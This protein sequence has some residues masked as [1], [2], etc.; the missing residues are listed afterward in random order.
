L[1]NILIDFGVP[2]KQVRL[3]EICLNETY[4][5][6]KACIHKHLSDNFPT[7]NGLKQGDALSS[8]LFNYACEYAIRK[9]LENQEGLKLNGTTRTE[10][11]CFL[12]DPCRDVISRTSACW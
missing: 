2:M 9:V 1:Y 12:C 3:I 7:Q 11:W 10:E 4:N 8:L 5:N 6:V